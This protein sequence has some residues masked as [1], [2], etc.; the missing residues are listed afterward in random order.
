[1]H[2]IPTNLAIHIEL[3]D[4]CDKHIPWVIAATS[5]ILIGNAAYDQRLALSW[6]EIGI[7]LEPRAIDPCDIANYYPHGPRL[8]GLLASRGKSK[9]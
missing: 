7:R 8:I 5:S 9:W 4:R 6:L 2:D 1:L 3:W